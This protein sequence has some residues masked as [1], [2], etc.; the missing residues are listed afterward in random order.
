[1]FLKISQVDKFYDVLCMSIL[2]FAFVFYQMLF[3]IPQ[4]S[5]YFFLRKKTRKKIPKNI[6]KIFYISMRYIIQMRF[7]FD[8]DISNKFHLYFRHLNWIK[9]ETHFFV[10][11]FI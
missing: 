1:M 3:E 7:S 8:V 5:A 9:N 4:I 10:A 11:L 2:D 6:E